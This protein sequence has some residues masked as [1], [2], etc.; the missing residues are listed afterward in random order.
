MPQVLHVCFVPVLLVLASVWVLVEGLGVSPFCSNSCLVVHS[1]C[2]LAFVVGFLGGLF[3]AIPFGCMLV[4]LF[5]FSDWSR[6]L[7]RS[8]LWG[9]PFLVLSLGLERLL[10]FCREGRPGVL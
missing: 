6:V 2:R 5:V 1:L 10:C 8:G 4:R 7:L 9:V 3:A